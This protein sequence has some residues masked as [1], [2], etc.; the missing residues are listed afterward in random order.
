VDSA[1]HDGR[2]AIDADISI[3]EISMP[4]EIQQFQARVILHLVAALQGRLAYGK[5]LL[6]R[7]FVPLDETF[8]ATE[9][10]LGEAK[11]RVF[12]IMNDW[13]RQQEQEPQLN[14][15][16]RSMIT[17]AL[18]FLAEAID[19]VL[20]E[21]PADPDDFISVVFQSRDRIMAL[22]LMLRAQAEPVGSR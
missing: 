2:P 6:A 19:H 15:E 8:S 16:V 14:E 4:N 12:D 17:Q 10:D 13:S 21:P 7:S 18:N 11:V 9:P 22:D 3:M 5:I 20:A 1:Y